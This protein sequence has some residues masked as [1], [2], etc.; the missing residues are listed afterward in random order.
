MEERDH[1][2]TKVKAHVELHHA[3]T[4]RKTLILG[5]SWGANV[6]M[7]FL[8]GVEALQPGW[9]EE[10]IAT[11]VDIGGPLLGAPKS[12][13]A[14]LSGMWDSC[15]REEVVESSIAGVLHLGGTL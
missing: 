15:W 5:H 13:S 7:N 9:V 10:H 3:I 2:F 6:A 4:G 11:F 12:I 8:Y 14:L 1:W